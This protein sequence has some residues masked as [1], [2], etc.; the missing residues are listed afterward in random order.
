MSDPELIRIRC[1]L[2][3]HDGADFSSLD[4]TRNPNDPSLTNDLLDLWDLTCRRGAM[5]DCAASMLLCYRERVILFI[6]PRPDEAHAIAQLARIVRDLT[7]D[8]EGTLYRI[9]NGK[10]SRMNARDSA[11]ESGRGPASDSTIDR[12]TAGKRSNKLPGT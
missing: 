3:R 6:S 10:V 8:Q 9:A 11:G 4:V 7:S 5:H 1:S 12:Q 2:T